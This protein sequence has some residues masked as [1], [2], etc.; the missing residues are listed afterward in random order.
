MTLDLSQ[1][2]DSQRV[3]VTWDGGPL[4][5]L[6]GPGSGKT[7]VLTSR[8]AHI[9]EHSPKAHFRVLALTFTNQAAAEMRERLLYMATRDGVDRTLLTTFHSFAGEILRQHGHLVGLRP[10]FAIMSQ[11]AD[12]VAL[13]EEVL[14]EVEGVEEPARAAERLLPVVAHLL[15]HAV[16]EEGAANVL[17]AAGSEAAAQVAAAYALYRARMIERNTLDFGGLLATTLDLLRNRTAVCRQIQRIYTYVCVD[18]FQDTNEVQYEILRHLVRNGG[19]NLFVVA[20]DDQI[21]YQWNGA[22]PERLRALKQDF[23]T[24][25]HQLPENYRCPPKVIALANALIG[26]N[27]DRSPGKEALTARK[28]VHLDDAVRLFRFAHFSEEA[29]WV[30]KDIGSRPAAARARSV[31]LARARRL[32]TEVIGKLEEAGVPA[33]LATRKDEFASEPMR[34]VHG[35]LRLANARQDRGHLRRVCKAFYAIEGINLDPLDIASSAIAG[36]EGD[37]L[38][39]FVAAALARRELDPRTRALLEG[40][41]ARLLDRLEFRNFVSEVF[42]WLA[43]A[44]A[45][46]TPSEGDETVYAEEKATWHDLIAEIERQYGAEQIT[47][48]LLLQELDM[49]SKAPKPLPGSI[50]CF[51]IHASKGLEFDHVYLV[52]LVEE[53]LPSWAALK[54]GAESRELQEERRNCFVAITRCQE[55]LTLTYSDVVLGWRKQPSRFLS[56]MGLV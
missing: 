12:R 27:Q 52:G 22:S 40:P 5:V 56:E 43:S 16:N 31:V 13:L 48:H 8:I 54:K 37:F 47:L 45:T 26:C 9:L 49:R 34:W 2:N 17:E 29:A 23:G 39:A 20:D 33:H 24:A 14:R 19:A 1:L 3:A 36:H 51:T 53:Q 35:I 4:L 55:T 46:G 18:E 30:A 25:I 6:A 7:R 21:I 28:T 42:P 11:D 15:D 10:D 41:L 50:P 44:L 38:R 32:L